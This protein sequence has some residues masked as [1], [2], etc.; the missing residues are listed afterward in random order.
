MLPQ[1]PHAPISSLHV[2]IHCASLASMLLISNTLIAA[3]VPVINEVV[4]I[5]QSSLA[6]DYA[7]SKGSTLNVNGGSQHGR[8]TATGSTLNI[9][10]GST[11]ASA[12]VRNGSDMSMNGAAISNGLEVNNSTAAIVGSTVTSTAGNGLLINRQQNLT[13]GSGVSLI[14]SSSSGALA[15]A[16]VTHFSQLELTGSQ[17]AG[18]G[19]SGVGLRLNAGA[20]QASASSIVGTVNGVAISSEAVYTDASLKLDSTQVVGQ[21]GAAIRIAP[22][23]SRLPGSVVAIDVSN[24]SSLTGGNGNM[25]E[26]TGASSAVMNVSASSLNGNVQVESASTVT[27]NLDN[28]SMTGDVLAEPGALADVLLDNNSV[29]TGRLENTRSVAI[30]NGAQWAMIGN[31][32]LA[33][34]NMN[35]GAVRFGDAAGFYTLSVANLAGNGTFIMDV[36]FAGGRSDFLD[37]T[38]TA[39][40]SH[41]LL[42]DS[43]GTDPSADA[44]LH[45]VHAGAGDA[46]F[47]L[48]GGAADLGAWSYD[49]V[50]QGTNDWYLDAQT[51]KVS[52]AAATVVALF[53][54]A[55]T[56]WYGELSSLR[57]RMGELRHNGGQSGAWMRTYGNKF[58][59]SDAS[60][61]GY[62]QTQQG[63]SLGADGKV[64]MGDGQ[65]LAGVMA[66]Q[67][68]SDLSLDRGASGKVGSY[69]MGA[70][71]TWL[72]SD[73]G[74][75]F[76]GVLK[77]NRFKNK[78]R[79]NLSDGTRTKGDYSNSGVG[80]SLEF[81]RHI[82]LDHGYFVEPFGQLA[83]VIVQGKDYRLDNGMVT[84][85]DP[86]RSLVSKLGATAGRNFALGQGRTVQPYVRA[87]WV[88]EFAKNNEV[89]VNDNVF[90]NDLS[91]SRGELGLGVAASLSERLQLHADFEHSNGDRIEQPWGASVGI[92]YNW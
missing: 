26:V 4:N 70:Y 11:I 20:A 42:I 80:A 92:R 73:T 17:L 59:V 29:L 31:S 90:N 53:N 46:E 51:R 5:D 74:Y 54:T 75:Y 60:G 89:Q 30:N 3:P 81:G 38:G 41:S 65:W 23:I 58:N 18:T 47:S 8:I 45:V 44:S 9:S 68:S 55:P 76:D 83:G 52:P 67:S 86:T 71:S 10:A 56:V 69:Y 77:F 15:G 16:F 12:A 25:L 78:A 62:Q 6:N 61:F 85:G 1:N 28:S 87:A 27:L 84:E 49:L 40:G 22:L 34:L 79:V 19:V 2:V 91:G 32:A 14:N 72:D 39:T 48:V 66:G 64:P 35:G 63:F 57:T 37:I 82:K 33:D 36:D 7:L 50:K 43:T 13:T 24:G 21:T 88:R